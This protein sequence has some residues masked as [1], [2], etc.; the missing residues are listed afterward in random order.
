MTRLAFDGHLGDRGAAAGGAGDLERAAE[1][2]D[3]IAEC[4]AGPADPVVAQAA[5]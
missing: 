5:P 2:L 3:A 4:E 1:R